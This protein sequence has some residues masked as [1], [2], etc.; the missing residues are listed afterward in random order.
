MIDKKGQP[1]PGVE[2]IVTWQGGE[3]HF[4]TGLK[5][6]IDLG[7]ADFTMEPDGIYNLR[8]TNGGET[9]GKISPP[10]CKL[11]SGMAYKGGVKVIFGQP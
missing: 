11:D 8:L 4:F 6:Q 9:A 2:A 1:V 5:P 7:Y 10:N 3:D